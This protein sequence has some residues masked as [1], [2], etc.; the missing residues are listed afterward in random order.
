MTDTDGFIDGIVEN[1]FH[2]LPLIHRKLMKVDTDGIENSLSRPLLGVM[3][4]IDESG[5]CPV[6]RIGQKLMI[7]RPQMTGMIDRLV[8]LEMVERMPDSA[9]RRIINV[10]LTGKGKKALEAGSKVI[11][12]NIKTQLSQLKKQEMETLS[13]CLQKIRDIGMKLGQE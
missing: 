7:A 1:L 6:S 3:R 2:V 9:D 11:K 13:V 4:V 10:T 8:D 5:P 12:E